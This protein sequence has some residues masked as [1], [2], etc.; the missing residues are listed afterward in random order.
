MQ[1]LRRFKGSRA[2]TVLALIALSVCAGILGNGPRAPRRPFAMWIIYYGHHSPEVDA[3][4]LEARPAYLVA[5]TAHGLWAEVAGG[6]TEGLLQDVASLQEAGIRVLG[7]V[8]SGYGGRGSSGALDPV[9]CTLDTNQRLIASMAM[10]DRV[11]GVF[12]DECPAYPDDSD[13]EYYRRLALA[14]HASGLIIWGNVG[15]EDFDPWYFT[16]GGFDLMNSTE[17]WEGQELTPSPRDWGHRMS[18][19]ALG[20]NHDLEAAIALSDEACRQGLRCCYVTTSYLQLPAWMGP[21]AAHV[22]QMDGGCP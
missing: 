8:T 9:W 1:P 15:Q 21:L 18:V 16:G 2:F 20:A 7:Y 3:R 22:H 13:Q 6:H 12:I 14:A 10:Q 17:L 11:D 19:I 5:N 4:I